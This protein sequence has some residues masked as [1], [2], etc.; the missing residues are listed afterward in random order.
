MLCT[1]ALV[2]IH[3]LKFDVIALHCDPNTFDSHWKAFGCL[4]EESLRD[5]LAASKE[6]PDCECTSA[7]LQLVM[8][9]DLIMMGELDRADRHL[10]NGVTVLG[11]DTTTIGNLSVAVAAVWGD[12]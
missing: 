1:D 9:E 6:R 5:A 10:R 11:Y 2:L 7:L 4:C 12:A 3:N 8:A